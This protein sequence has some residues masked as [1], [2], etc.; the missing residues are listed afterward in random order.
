M[1]SSDMRRAVLAI[2]LAGTELPPNNFALA[3]SSTMKILILATGPKMFPDVRST[4]RNHL[5]WRFCNYLNRE[6]IFVFLSTLALCKDDPNGNVPLGKSC[7]RYWNCQ[8][9]YPRLQRC[10][11]MLVFDKRSLRCV[12]PPTEDCDIPSTTPPPPQ[13]EE[14]QPSAPSA[15]SSNSRQQQSRQPI[16]ANQLRNQ[17]FGGARPIAFTVENNVPQQRQQQQQQQQQQYSPQQQQSQQRQ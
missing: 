14:D 6:L 4:V 3:D 13:E 11:A 1:V 9:G 17:D 2:G 5:A 15:P 8:G 16:Q 12:V 10:P 7:N